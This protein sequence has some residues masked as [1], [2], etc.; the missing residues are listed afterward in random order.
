MRHHRTQAQSIA[1]EIEPKLDLS[2]LVDVSFLLLIFFLVTST[3][4]TP[5]ADLRVKLGHPEP[6]FQT[7]V[8]ERPLIEIDAGGNIYL[9][10]EL[11]E[12]ETDSRKL[13]VLR[14]RLKSFVETFQMVETGH[15]PSV[16]VSADNSAKGQRFIDV[17]NCLAHF[18]ISDVAIAS[19]GIED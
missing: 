17:L 16:I 8:F 12:T 5:D 19:F 11:L 18:G 9:T 1:S 4:R 10:D 13:P 3:L 6:G 7:V 2:S 15:D 14:D